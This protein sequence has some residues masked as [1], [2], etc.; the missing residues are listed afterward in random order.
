MANRFNVAESDLYGR[1]IFLLGTS[2]LGP[3]NTPVQAMSPSHV[4]S[5]FGEKGTLLDAYR[6]IKETDYNCDV[7]LVKVTGVHSELYLDINVPQSGEI[8]EGGFYIKAKYANEKYDDIKVIIDDDALYIYYNSEELGDYV[9]EYK[10][11]MEDED[12]NPILDKQGRKVYKTLID[13][14]EEINDDTRAL[15]GEIYCYANCDPFV[16]S[17]TAL[18]AVNSSFNTLHG[19]NSGLYYN[20]NMMYNCLSDTYGILEG[21]DIDIIIPLGC[22]YDDT[23]TD[24]QDDLSEYYDLDRE[25]L[26]LSINDNYLSYYKQLLEFCKIQMRFGMLTNGIMGMNLVKDPFIDEDAYIKKLE[27]FKKVNED[28]ELHDKYRQLVSVCVGDIYCTYG[29]RVYNSYLVYAPLVADL[30]ITE[31]TTN[32]PI[33]K[34]FT[35]FNDFD[36]RNLNKIKDLGYTA[37]RYSILKKRVVVANGVTTSSDESF[38]YLCNIRMCQLTMCYVNDLLKGFIGKNINTLI[39]T[40]EIEQKL[41]TLFNSLVAKGILSGFAINSITNPSTGHIMLDMSFKTAYML[42]N[43]RAYA[44]L[45]N[46]SNR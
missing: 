10:Y 42:E 23:F 7:Y 41:I 8:I 44:G 28:D 19:G 43:I 37:F 26:T 14:A 6:V 34:S 31:N 11:H 39:Q 36:T 21:R 38:K 46:V 2:D 1:K 3:L 29:T 12:G 22:Y 18:V 16:P 20:K 35:M 32:K 4:K 9:S 17:N 13:L 25:Y 45:A 5:V 40:R 30:S 33:P 24:N 15:N 27:H